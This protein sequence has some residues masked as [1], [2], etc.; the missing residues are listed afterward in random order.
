MR[1]LIGH[2]I[3]DI[4]T[5]ALVVDVD[6][7]KGNIERLQA[8]C[9]EA[10]LQLRPHTKA[11]KTPEIALMQT[12]AGAAGVTVAKLGEAEVMATAGIE[13]IFIANQ[14]IGAPKMARLAAL[15]RRVPRLSVAVDSLVSAGQM[16]K[17]LRAEGLSIDVLIEVDAGAGRCGVAPNSLLLFAKQLGEYNSLRLVGIMAYAGPAY[18]ARGAEA[19][20]RAAAREAEELARIAGTL[21]RAGYRMERISGGTTPTGERY[22]KGCGLTEVRSGTYC[23]NDY[24]QVDLGSTTPDRVAATVLATVIS[25]PTVDRAIVDAGSKAM[26]LQVSQ[27]SDGYGF[28]QGPKGGKLSKVN[29]EHGYLDVR[30]MAGEVEIGEKLRLMPP[31]ICTALNL[32]DWMY[33]VEGDRV[34]DVW[35]VAARGANT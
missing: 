8:A 31:R 12:R 24:N 29:D 27:L 16:D 23:L 20:E 15:A 35:R 33:A 21:T 2:P 19:F 22:K 25:H 9:D 4:D 10:E 13:D 7:L 11:H 26:G 32:Y 14:L 18:E 17:A 1:S 34:V 3:E 28:V 5:P 6:V 30:G